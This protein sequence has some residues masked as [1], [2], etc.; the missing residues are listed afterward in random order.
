MRKTARKFSKDERRKAVAKGFADRDKRS[1]NWYLVDESE[2]K[3]L[4]IKKYEAK[5]GSTSYITIL[6]RTDAPEFFMEIY[7]H[8][9][10]GPNNDAFLCVNRMYGDKCPVCDFGR[11]LHDEGEDKEVTKDYFPAKR[12]LLWVVD[13]KDVGSIAEGIQLY[14]APKTVFDG[15]AELSTDDRTGEITDVSDPE[16]KVTFVFKR[17]GKGRTGTSYIGFKLEEWQDDVPEKY[18]EN[19]PN[20]EELLVKPDIETIKK[21]MG[22]DVREEDGENEEYTEQYIDEDVIEEEA[23]AEYKEDDI[24]EE[25]EEQEEIEPEPEEK[26]KHRSRKIKRESV[27]DEEIKRTS[28]TVKSSIR[29]RMKSR[30][31][32]R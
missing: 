20:M 10:M 19:L 32:R 1:G 25:D 14:E 24:N 15:I 8:Y 11:K 7:V 16:E 13:S 21:A 31:E 27:E 26:P 30:K 6:P 18:Y 22:I 2:F 9:S 4:G 29:S 3:K 28:D 5:S 17:M 23:I 12:Y